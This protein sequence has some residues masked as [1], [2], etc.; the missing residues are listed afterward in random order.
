VQ[1]VALAADG[2][3]PG[4][5]VR[6]GLRA[7]SVFAT[8]FGLD[9]LPAVIG[10]LHAKVAAVACGP[11]DAGADHH[12]L[13][14]LQQTLRKTGRRHCRLHSGTRATTGALLWAGGRLTADLRRLGR[15]IA[16]QPRPGEE[17]DTPSDT[18]VTPGNPG[19]EVRVTSPPQNVRDRAETV[20]Y[21][22]HQVTQ[23]KVAH[24]VTVHRGE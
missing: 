22:G 9:A 23:R 14:A 2:P 6:H 24:W 12:R 20:N 13:N 19:Q 15:I 3:G 21:C 8:P 1:V 18:G 16:V 17:R 5:N 4:P 10:K 11:G 7:L